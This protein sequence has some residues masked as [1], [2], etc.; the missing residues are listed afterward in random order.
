MQS[1]S[2]EYAC[3][4]P[5]EETPILTDFRL[6]LGPHSH[7]SRFVYAYM[8]RLHVYV[9]SVS[10]HVSYGIIKNIYGKLW[11]IMAEVRI[12]IMAGNSCCM[13]VVG[14]SF[15]RWGSHQLKSYSERGRK[16]R[17]YIS[18]TIDFN[19]FTDLRVFIVK[20]GTFHCIYA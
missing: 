14:I 3:S 18:E 4:F 17:P 12:P 7:V 16:W 15:N 5:K 11:S 1:I 2:T 13:W 20:V 19:L 6:Y 10:V 9:C 8:F